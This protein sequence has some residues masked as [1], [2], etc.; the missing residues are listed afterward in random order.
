MKSLKPIVD[1]TTSTM[2]ATNVVADLRS[3]I[4]TLQSAINVLSNNLDGLETQI[5]SQDITKQSGNFNTINATNGNITNIDASSIDTNT[6]DANCANI[7]GISAT[8]INATNITGGVVNAGNA[9][10]SCLRGGSASF[11]DVTTTCFNS[12]EVRTPKVIA[13]CANISNLNAPNAS[14]GE[15]TVQTLNNP[16]TFTADEIDT[17][18][19]DADNAT[20]DEATIGELTS[21]VSKLDSLYNNNKAFVYDE[22]DSNEFIVLGEPNDGSNE[23]SVPRFIEIPAITNG[24]YRI[25]VKK[26]DNNYFS[27][28][29]I[30]TG[31]APL[32]IYDKA[33]AGDIDTLYYDSLT[34]K[35][36]VKTYAS[37]YIYWCN[38]A[39]GLNIAPVTWTELPIDPSEITTYRYGTSGLHRIVIMGDNSL[40]YGLTVQGVLE[41]NI[42]KDNTQYHQLFF[43]GNSWVA[44]KAFADKFLTF[45]DNNG[46]KHYGQSEVAGYLFHYNPDDNTFPMS[47]RDSD[48]TET[49]SLE[50]IGYD[51]TKVTLTVDSKYGQDDIEIDDTATPSLLTATLAAGTYGENTLAT[52][53]SVPVNNGTNNTTITVPDGFNVHLDSGDYY[54]VDGI[55]VHL[56]EPV[57]LTES[58]FEYDSEIDVYKAYVPVDSHDIFDLLVVVNTTEHSYSAELHIILDEETNPLDSSSLA[59]VKATFNTPGTYPWVI[60]VENNELV[61]S[62]FN[63]FDVTSNTTIVGDEPVPMDNT[64]PF[65]ISFTTGSYRWDLMMNDNVFNS[66]ASERG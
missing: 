37:G 66:W 62:V 36:Y 65:I 27:V 46:N 24:F 31:K 29:L 59:K 34:N 10:I 13:T 55:M 12:D 25:T 41:A 8:N 42:I 23:N 51:G 61:S 18:L 28:M 53:I 44:L 32:V 39:K 22:T 14:I 17:A 60:T 33:E 11:D 1:K 9:S 63:T 20:I 15:L 3:Q 56:N 49:E 7:N 57:D 16:A 6:I 35:L 58:D 47:Y 52:S 64:L 40:D 19:I 21:T 38:D 2:I 54:S 45:E 43:Y 4:S 50:K 5:Q 30:T 48:N 26:A